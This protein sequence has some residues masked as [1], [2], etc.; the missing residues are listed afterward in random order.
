MVVKASA[1]GGGKGIEVARDEEQLGRVYDAARRQGRAYFADDTVFMERY[2]DDPRH[3]E[4]QVLADSHDCRPF[5]RRDCTIQR[6]HQKIIEE[7]PSI[8]VSAEL[9]D[10]IGRIG[11]E[12]ARAVGYVKRARSRACSTLTAATSSSR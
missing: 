12:A 4:V 9:R 8:A 1:G 11:V 3:V 5:W 6:R 7:T 10:R 2:L